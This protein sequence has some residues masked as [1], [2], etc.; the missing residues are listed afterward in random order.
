MTTL[1]FRPTTA[2]QIKPGNTVFFVRFGVGILTDV[3]TVEQVE[4]DG[5]PCIRVR[6]ATGDACLLP[7]DDEVYVRY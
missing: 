4:D 6:N 5:C 2:K 7:A 1:A 3:A